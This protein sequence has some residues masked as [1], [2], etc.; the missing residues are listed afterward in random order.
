MKLLTAKKH[1]DIVEL[2]FSRVAKSPILILVQNAC[3][4]YREFNQYL[5]FQFHL[6]SI[7]AVIMSIE[8]VKRACR[9]PNV[10]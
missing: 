3:V 8:L 4:P 5:S 10:P 2:V 7:P 6:F 9:S 1:D